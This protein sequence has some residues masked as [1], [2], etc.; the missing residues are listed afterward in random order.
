MNMSDVMRQ[1]NF[2][3]KPGKEEQ[4]RCDRD[5]LYFLTAILIILVTLAIFNGEIMSFLTSA[6]F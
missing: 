5:A 4:N 1:S 6:L 3:R 2:E